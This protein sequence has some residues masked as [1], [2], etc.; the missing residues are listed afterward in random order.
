[1]I[2]PVGLIYAVTKKVYE[3]LR[4]LR[5]PSMVNKCSVLIVTFLMAALQPA[6][7]QKAAVEDP[8]YSAAQSEL[9]R[10]REIKPIKRRARNVILFLADGM[11]PT[12]VAAT[13]IF[14]GQTRGEQG[15]ENY[16]SF[17]AF[18]HLAMAKTYNTDAQTPDSAGTMSAIVT[19]VKT[20]IGVISMTDAVVTG[21][22][23][24]SKGAEAATIIELAE[25][26]GMATGVISTAR[27]THA[28]PAATYAHAADRD[29][30]VDARLPGEAIAAG[31]RDIASQLIDFPYGDGLEIA[32]GGGRSN[33]LPND[34]PDPEY[35][36]TRGSRQD[37]RDLT[38]EWVRKSSNHSYVWNAE[39]FNDLDA[40][41]TPRI[42]GL[43]E[44]THMRYEADR[45]KD[46]AGEPSLAAMTAKAI[47][48]LSAEDEGYVLIVE[49]GRVDH[50]HHRGNAARALRDTQAFA[51]AIAIANDKTSDRETLIIVTADHS[52]T[53]TFAGYP[54][55]GNDIL[56][57]VQ[58]PPTALEPGQKLALAD[59]GKPY[60][61][62]G[63]ANGPGAVMKNQTNGERA[64]PTAEAVKEINYRQAAAIF[65]RSE[66]HG[67]QDVGIYASGP[68][69][70]L[71][72]GTVEQNYVFHVI[73]YALNLNA[74]AEK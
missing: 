15:E 39:Q 55:K 6:Q 42:L 19:G 68:R 20:K 2:K 37:G 74:R 30:E 45:A 67:G 61:T 18:P 16:L 66:T 58:S 56:G 13:R 65:K 62:L 21:D 7:A 59:D 31:C 44:R 73:E 41:D 47:D 54:R 27:L 5:R 40:A 11:G 71:F 48:I 50:A 28:T 36:K 34:Q 9:E 12:T 52:H 32:I 14:D 24:A 63:Y 25:S 22:C 57:L 38:A 10:R 60:T 69:A 23:A 64:V 72:D 51:E 29:W 53:L 35:P 8:Y 1:M 26:A 3:G 4:E 17:E 33:F 43:F 49:A 70:Y 46:V